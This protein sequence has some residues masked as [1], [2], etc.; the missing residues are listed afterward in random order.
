MR[1][2][3][4]AFFGLL[5]FHLKGRMEFLALCFGYLRLWYPTVSLQLS[6]NEEFF[7]SRFIYNMCSEVDP[8]LNPNSPL[9]EY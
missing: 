7:R 1:G 5:L 9:F 3:Y 4:L 8:N 6:D 2:A